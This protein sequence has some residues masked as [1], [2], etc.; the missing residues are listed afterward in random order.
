[1]KKLVMIIPLV[2]LLCFA[3]NCQQGEEMAEIVKPAI[4]AEADIK[5][6]KNFRKQFMIAQRDQDL[7]G[8][9]SFWCEDCVYMPSYGPVVIGKDALR[10]WYKDFFDR[11]KYDVTAYIDQVEIAGNW[12]IVR[13]S[14][15]GTLTIKAQNRSS[16]VKSKFIDILKRQS[17]GSWKFAWHM[18]NRDTP[19]PPFLKKE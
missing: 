12:G 16:E 2:I 6:I 19:L 18:W 13:G 3:F 17:D 7:E 11:I 15:K 10:S 8:C 9:L 14:L 4:N 5:A 1:M